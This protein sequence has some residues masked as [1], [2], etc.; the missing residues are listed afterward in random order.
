MKIFREFGSAKHVIPI[1]TTSG[2][3]IVNR[4]FHRVFRLPTSID[5][6]ERHLIVRPY[7]EAPAASNTYLLKE[8]FP[9]CKSLS[10]GLQ[11]LKQRLCHITD[12]SCKYSSARRMFLKIE[13]IYIPFEGLTKVSHVKYD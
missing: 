5:S 12:M 10:N 3:Y 1:S 13:K 8:K 4:E 7:S 9:F 6:G 11:M 2:L